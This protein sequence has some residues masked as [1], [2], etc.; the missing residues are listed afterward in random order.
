MSLFILLSQQ[1]KGW[2]MDTINCFHLCFCVNSESKEKNVISKTNWRQELIQ[3][4]SLC[5]RKFILN[6]HHVTVLLIAPL[7]H[8]EQIPLCKLVNSLNSDKYFQ[9]LLYR[10]NYREIQNI[11][12]EQLPKQWRI[13]SGVGNSI[14]WHTRKTD[15]TEGILYWF[16]KMNCQDNKWVDWKTSVVLAE[17][18]VFNGNLERFST[19]RIVIE[20]TVTIK[21][22]EILIGVVDRWKD[23][24]HLWN[25]QF[26]GEKLH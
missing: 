6:V 4:W 7:I 10:T 16:F 22:I 5:L 2:S 14:Q 18:T 26:I 8:M 11:H 12:R 1:I 3:C 17:M 19:I 25:W 23:C 20:Y 24:W 15:R 13:R 9:I 21:I